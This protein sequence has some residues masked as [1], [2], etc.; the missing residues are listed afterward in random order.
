MISK[1]AAFNKLWSDYERTGSI[2][3]VEP[4]MTRDELRRILGEPD[5]TSIRGRRRPLEGIW[6]FGRVE[7]HFDTDERLSLIYT[8]DDDLNPQVIAKDP[9]V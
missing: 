4:G 3:P 2:R 7:F 6:K 1:S 5:D 9:A 8:E